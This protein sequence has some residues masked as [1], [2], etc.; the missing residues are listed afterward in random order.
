MSI[1]W[2]SSIPGCVYCI[3]TGYWIGSHLNPEYCR[4]AGSHEAVISDE[5]DRWN[6]LNQEETR[7]NNCDV[8][9]FGRL[10]VNMAR[11]PRWGRTPKRMEKI[12]F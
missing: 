10:P 7:S 6:E 8:L 4:S 2:S 11:D 9:T 5:A 12:L 3:P 1:T